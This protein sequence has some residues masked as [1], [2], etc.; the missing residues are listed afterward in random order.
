MDLDLLQAR[1][2]LYFIGKYFMLDQ[3]DSSLPFRYDLTFSKRRR[4]IKLAVRSGRVLVCAPVGTSKCYLHDLLKQ[5]QLWIEKHLKQSIVVTKID[6]LQC[7]TI[8]IAGEWRPFDWVLSSQNGVLVTETAFNVL[9]SK[10]VSELRRSYYIQQQVQKY[11]TTLASDFFNQEVA[12]QSSRM[13]L[14]PSAII[15]GNWRRRWGYCDN[16]KRLGFNWRLLQAPDWVARYVVIHELAHLR[17]MNHSAEFWHLVHDFCPNY[18]TAQ[19][20]LK[21]H[22]HLLW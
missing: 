13:S 7:K 11:F 20:W 15:I 18:K 1:V 19:K 9:V 4:T 12:L 6:W 5:K 2:K 22:Q 10:R 8:L 3:Y 14:D 17:H 21:Q 16:Q